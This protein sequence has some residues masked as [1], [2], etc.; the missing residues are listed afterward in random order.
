MDEQGSPDRF[1]GLNSFSFK[2]IASRIFN[3]AG[4]Q[5]RRAAKTNGLC[6]HEL[7]WRDTTQ[8]P[9]RGHISGPA[10]ISRGG[11]RELGLSLAS[12]L[13]LPLQTIGLPTL[14]QQARDSLHFASPSRQT[15]GINFDSPAIVFHLG[16][17]TAWQIFQSPSCS[18]SVMSVVYAPIRSLSNTTHPA[19]RA[20]I[21]VFQFVMGHMLP[22][23]VVTAFPQ[24]TA[25]CCLATATMV[26][27]KVVPSMMRQSPSSN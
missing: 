3:L 19:S 5:R 24:L 13:P 8:N 2:T 18:L 25:E 6:A 16:A 1:R 20:P 26:Q 23:S 10:K 22:V 12:V 27:P 4:N 7:C 21:C 15:E 17:D 11:E 9:V 14:F